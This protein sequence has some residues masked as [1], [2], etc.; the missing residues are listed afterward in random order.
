MLKKVDLDSF[1]MHLAIK[2]FPVPGGPKSK[3]PFGGPLS[4]VKRSGLSIGQITISCIVFFTNSNPAISLQQI[5][6]VRSITFHFYRNDEHISLRAWWFNIYSK[7]FQ[8]TSLEMISISFGSTF[9]IVAARRAAC[10][11][12]SLTGALSLFCGELAFRIGQL[13]LLWMPPF[14]LALR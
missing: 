3:S 7:E 5:G 13:N 6:G 10:S 11:S 8:Y 2:V 9:F 4:P 12:V 14:L 1:A